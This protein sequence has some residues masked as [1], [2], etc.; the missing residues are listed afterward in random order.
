[1]YALTSS[2]NSLNANLLQLYN[3][4]L[5]NG[6]ADI[7]DFKDFATTEQQSAYSTGA[8]AVAV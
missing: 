8:R 7:V 3:A 2:S 1:M 5:A 4:S 6:A